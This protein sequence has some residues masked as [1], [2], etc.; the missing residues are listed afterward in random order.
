VTGPNALHGE[1]P[2]FPFPGRPGGEHDEPLLDIIIARRAL[3]PDAPAAMHDLARMLAAM[4]GPTEPGEMVGEMAV[5]TAFSRV[6]SPVGI[7]SEAQ[8]PARRR[9]TRQSYRPARSPAMLVSVVVAAVAGFGSV[10]AAYA[11]V[12]PTPIQQ[13][14]HVTVAAPAPHQSP[15]PLP[16]LEGGK[17]TDVSPRPE[18]SKVSAN[19]DEGDTPSPTPGGHRCNEVSPF[20]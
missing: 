10:M 3:P 15:N 1:M 19:A 16:T 8:Q 5:R 20:P 12:L 13:L 11:D 6:A 4:A 9:R 17:R 18:C 2:G 7:S 14:A